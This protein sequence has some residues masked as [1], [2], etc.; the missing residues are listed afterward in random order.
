MPRISLWR[1]GR[2]TND[3]RFFDRNIAEFMTASGTGVHIHKYLGPLPQPDSTDI[4]QPTNINTSE[5]A[6]QDLL[7]LE[8]RDRKY[9]Q[10]VYRLRGCYQVADSAFDLSQFGLFLQTGTLYM[11]FHLNEMVNALGRRLMNGDVIE[12]QHLID[13]DVVN[14]D[15]PAALKRYFVVSDCT[16]GAEG[17]SPTWWP[18]IWRCKLNPLVDSQEYS[19]ILKRITVS[20]DNNTPL[21]DIMSTYSRHIEVNTSVVAQA[22]AELPKSGYDTTPIWHRSLDEQTPNFSVNSYLGN[23]DIAPNG[24][25]AT[26]GITFPV[27][28][29]IGDYCLRI[30]FLP[31]RLFRW[32]GVRWRRIEDK[33]RS[34]IT[35]N[36]VDNVTQ[37]NTFITNSNTYRDVNNNLQPQKQSLHE[38]LKPKAD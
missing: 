14:P 27:D 25:P 37:R 18:H 17:Y 7:F 2:H 5:T 15:L 24:E 38:I 6:I 23:T 30:D 19:D 16:R 22:E 33:V 1:D 20:D 13:Y 26:Q 11:T 28:P 12:L 31:N 4:S 9:E 29:S 10:D 36:A 8:N 21:R 3:Y 34:N 32:D 35:N